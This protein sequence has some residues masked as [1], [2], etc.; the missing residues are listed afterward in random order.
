MNPRVKEVKILENYQLLLTFNNG[1]KRIFDAKTLF[2]YEFYKR[3][4]DIENF[5]TVK[6]VDGITIEWSTGEDVDPE[7]LY[8]NSTPIK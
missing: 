4:K 1:E 6:A 2:K 3:I 5:R 8:L 7:K